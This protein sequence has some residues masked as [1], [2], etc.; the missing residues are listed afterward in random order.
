MQL[1]SLISEGWELFIILATLFIAHLLS[2]SFF[3]FIS[4]F[5]ITIKLKPLLF[6]QYLKFSKNG[7]IA[8]SI[9]NL[10][11][12]N[13]IEFAKIVFGY[14]VVDDSST[15]NTNEKILYIGYHSRTTLDSL[16][17]MASYQTSAV[18]HELLCDVPLIGDFLTQVLGA[19]PSQARLYDNQAESKLLTHLL[20]KTQ[21]VYL[22]PGGQY[23]CLKY[24]Y[25]SNTLLWKDKAGFVRFILKH[26]DQLEHL[27]II[28]TYTKNCENM[29]YV[30]PYMHDFVSNQARTLTES[31]R[32]GHYYII[33]YAFTILIISVAFLAVPTCRKVETH[34]GK[35]IIFTPTLLTQLVGDKQ[36]GKM[37]SKMTKVSDGEE[38]EEGEQEEVEEEEEEEEEEAVILTKHIHTE[39]QTFIN[40]IEAIPSYNH[41][42]HLIYTSR[43]KDNYTLISSIIS[44]LASVNNCFKLLTNILIL[45]IQNV[46]YFGTIIVICWVIYLPCA[47]IVFVIKRM[48]YMI[49][50]TKHID[51]KKG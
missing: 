20:T 16:F 26:R 32:Q 2:W 22:L 18:I 47:I 21:P 34:I 40:A 9:I 13:I 7:S 51:K 8:N 24:S 12:G 28:P 1:L 11:Y 33:P 44:L 17:F 46:L 4:F 41:A 36:G 45:L 14:E 5:L 50:H 19:L 3:S 29:Y 31:V 48:L 49:W 6:P 42:Y 25:E 15:A 35:P 10:S 27:H 39:F 23:E 43:H 38:E 37:Y 30:I